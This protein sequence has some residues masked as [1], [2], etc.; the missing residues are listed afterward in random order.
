[1]RNKRMSPS[2]VSMRESIRY[3]IMFS[4]D[5]NNMEINIVF[6]QIVNRNTKKTIVGGLRH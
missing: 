4:F 2:K 1:M 3:D 6:N 5:M